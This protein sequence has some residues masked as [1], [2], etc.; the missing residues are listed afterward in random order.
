GAIAA[1]SALFR[2]PFLAFLIALFTVGA[3]LMLW[4]ELLVREAGV[5]VIVLMLP[6]AFA[7]FVWPAR[8]IWAI[9]SVELLLAL[10]LSKFVIVAVLSLGGAA[11]GHGLSDG[12]SNALA[13]VVMLSLGAFAPWALLRL[14]PLAEM[15]TSAGG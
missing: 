3:A 11:L 6:I 8:R 7:A 1:L 13:G 10:I 12:L 15:A 4:I 5:Y 9:R 14:V 2:S